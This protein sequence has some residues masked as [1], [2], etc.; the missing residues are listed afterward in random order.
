M[1]S[2]DFLSFFRK[3]ITRKIF[4]VKHTCYYKKYFIPLLLAQWQGNANYCADFAVRE[5]SF[6]FKEYCGVVYV[7][8]CAE[9]MVM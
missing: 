9:K 5:L 6:A 3:L 4:I 2:H 1:L 7:Y 8:V